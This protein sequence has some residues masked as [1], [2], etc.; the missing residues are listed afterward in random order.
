MAIDYDAKFLEDI[1]LLYEIRQFITH[2][3]SEGVISQEEYD[4][5]SSDLKK[6]IRVA[7]GL[8]EE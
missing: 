4:N 5:H 2:L 8:P 1:K 7:M 3:V 6:A